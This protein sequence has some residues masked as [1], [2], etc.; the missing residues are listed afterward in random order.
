M[1]SARVIVCQ[2]K[3]IYCNDMKANSCASLYCTC[4]EFYCGSR[5]LAIDHNSKGTRDEF[6]CSKGGKYMQLSG[7]A[8]L[9]GPT[10][11]NLALRC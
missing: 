10:S 11:K 4:T 6:Q 7:V 8:E 2:R 9:E 1:F 5:R 3:R